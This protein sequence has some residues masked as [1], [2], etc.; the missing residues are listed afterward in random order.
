MISCF[1]WGCEWSNWSR[2]VRSWKRL[3]RLPVRLESLFDLV[4]IC[5]VMHTLWAS[6]VCRVDTNRGHAEVFSYLGVYVGRFSL[7][8]SFFFFICGFYTTSD[9]PSPQSPWSV[10]GR[11]YHRGWMW[12]CFV[13]WSVASQGEKEQGRNLDRG[14]QKYFSFSHFHPHFLLDF[15]LHTT[16][17]GATCSLFTVV[18]TRFCAHPPTQSHKS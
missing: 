16:H 10:R 18:T 11:E 9:I 2:L 12:A 1:K 7:S 13:V 17:G 4:C 8:L 14:E 3:L 6:F 15:Y 5:T